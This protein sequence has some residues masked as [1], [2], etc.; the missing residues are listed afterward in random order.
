MKVSGHIL[1]EIPALL[2]RNL[3]LKNRL[4]IE[5]NDVHYQRT[6]NRSY[7]VVGLGQTLLVCQG[8]L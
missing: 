3:L 7:K 2:S 5:M 1:C 6:V 8:F 4:D